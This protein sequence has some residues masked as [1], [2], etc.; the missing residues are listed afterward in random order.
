MK[1][2]REMATELQNT[3]N[4]L[5]SKCDV[6]VEKY[7]ALQAEKDA[8]SQEY[9]KLK[10]Q[11]DL[12]HKELERLQQEKEFL[13]MARS[14]SPNDE[15]LAKNRAIIAKLVRDVDKCISQLME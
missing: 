9:E 13:I 15:V 1:I 4:R 14:V 5:V 6:L 2:W 7:K 11:A 10:L 3:L 12:Q 8:V